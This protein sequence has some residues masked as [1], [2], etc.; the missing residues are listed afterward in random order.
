[1]KEGIPSSIFPV[2]LLMAYVVS[3]SLDHLIFAIQISDPDYIGR[4]RTCGIGLWVGV[5]F[6][7]SLFWGRSSGRFG[8]LEECPFSRLL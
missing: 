4:W 1:M 3:V 5:L 8:I 2:K 7:A 6:F